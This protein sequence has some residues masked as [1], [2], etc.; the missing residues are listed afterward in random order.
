MS[1]EESSD[2]T[3]SI[4]PEMEA[5]ASFLKRIDEI[6]EWLRSGYSVKGVWIACTRGAPAFSGCYQTF[7]RYCRMHGLC[8]RRGTPPVASH[9]SS[10]PLGAAPPVSVIERTTTPQIWPRLSGKPR[11]FIPRTEDER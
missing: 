3:P 5:Y 8:V 4:P 2:P 9:R 1:K 10:A 6:S 7:W 11:E